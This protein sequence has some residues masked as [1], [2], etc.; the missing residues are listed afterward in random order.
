M[1]EV[2]GFIKFIY[3]C[4]VSLYVS[5]AYSLQTKFLLSV[6]Y[7]M[8][9]NKR[10][11]NKL[12]PIYIE[13]YGSNDILRYFLMSLYLPLFVF[14][15]MDICL[16][17]MYNVLTFVYDKLKLCP[18]FEPYMSLFEDHMENLNCRY[19]AEKNKVTSM[20]I[21]YMKEAVISNFMKTDNLM[22]TKIQKSNEDNKSSQNSHKMNVGISERMRKL[23]ETKGF[24]K[25]NK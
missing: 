20:A 18:V 4:V 7:M 9:R 19:I 16:N 23:K 22:K 14:K 13:E 10:I 5:F 17:F 12:I 8:K 3:F 15:Y 6:L 21:L 11:I 2:Y 1:L 25:K 24:N